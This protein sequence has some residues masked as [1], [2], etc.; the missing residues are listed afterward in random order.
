MIESKYGNYP[1]I[2][3]TSALNY[4]A[5]EHWIQVEAKLIQTLFFDEQQRYYGFFSMIQPKENW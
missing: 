3:I 2:D 1:T 5:I 4:Q